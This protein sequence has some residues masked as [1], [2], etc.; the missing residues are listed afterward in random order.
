M[1]IRIVLGFVAFELIAMLI[2]LIGLK[3]RNQ[4]KIFW[5]I[6]IVMFIGALLAIATGAVKLVHEDLT[7]NHLGIA[8]IFM[9]IIFAGVNVY[10]AEKLHKL[11]PKFKEREEA[12]QAKATASEQEVPIVD[13]SAQEEIIE[14]SKPE[15]QI[16][17]E[18][19]TID[20]PKAVVLSQR[21][22]TPLARTI[23]QKAIEAGI[24]TEFD[25]HY[26][27]LGSKV[28]L[29]YMCGRIYCDDY[30][31]QQQKSERAIWKFGQKDFF[32]DV[33]L[34]ELFNETDLAQSRQNRK[35]ESVPKNSVKIDD[36]FK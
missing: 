1:I 27:W 28:T 13:A 26:K 30:P 32:P 15:P 35:E 31:K 21:L 2:V 4:R 36:F 17:P 8:G 10:I 20:E 22:D 33:E 34:N 23:F 25:G 19:P 9:A 3:R 11:E 5:S 29:A 18:E 12:L 24:M 6:A 16:E 7:H 14:D